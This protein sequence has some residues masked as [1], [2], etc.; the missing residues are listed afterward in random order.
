MRWKLFL[1][2]AIALSGVIGVSAQDE[3]ARAEIVNDE[4]GPVAV[5]GTLTY[6]DVLFT[7]GV[8]EPLIVLEDQGGFVERNEGFILP[9]Q[10]QVLGQFTSDF[11][12][13][14]VN[15]TLALPEVPQGTMHD[16]DNDSETDDGVQIFAI[17]YWTNTFGDSYLEERDLFG[18][19]WSNAYASTRA[20]SD[21]DQSREIVGGKYLV[22]AQDD[23]Q[24]FPNEFGEDGLLFTGDETTVLLPAGYT[25]VDMDTTPFTFDR[26]RNPVIDLI[27]PESVALDD[28]SN[29]SY[30]E[31]FDAM[32]EK[33]RTEYAFT[34][35]KNIDWDAMSAEFRP[36]FE[37]AEA[38][39]DVDAYLLAMRDFTW[40][41]PDVHVSTY[42]GGDVVNQDFLV[43]SAGGLGMAIQDLTDDGTVVYFLTA[44]G[45]A[46]Q[47]GIEI[48]AEILEINGQPAN[49]VIDAV[50]PFSSPF[51]TDI[52]R[53]LQQL[54]Y[55]F[56]AQVGTD[57][58]ITYQNPGDSDPTTVT[59]TT[60]E[61]YNSFSVSSF[62]TGLTGFELP[63]DYRVLDSGLGYVKI[64]SF[65]DNSLLTIQLWERMIQSFNDAGV[66][67]LIIDMRQNG[68]GSGFLADQMAA[69]F[70][71]EPLV[72]G[73]GSVYDEKTGDWYTDPNTPSRFYLPPENLRYSGEVAVLV[74][75]SCVSACEF[76]SYAMTLEDRAAIVGQYPTAG[77]GGSIQDFAM[78]EGQYVRIPIGRNLDTEG[79][80][81]IEGTGVVPT[82]QVP[83]TLESLT[84]GADVVLQAAEAHLYDVLGVPTSPTG[85]VTIVDGG[86][87]TVDSSVSGE[88]NA[89]ERV[90]YTL[91]ADDDTTVN[92]TVGDADG[93]LDTYLRVYDADENLLA[94][95]DDIEL[96][97]QINSVI[98]GLQVAAGTPVIIEVGTYGD[99]SAGSFTLTVL[100]ASGLSADEGPVPTPVP[101]MTEAAEAGG[102]ATPEAEPTTVDAT[103]VPEITPE[104]TQES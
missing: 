37:Q 80:I 31:A 84:S 93:T 30:T 53:R 66:P 102:D 61:E 65:F 68:G 36:R 40:A 67:G 103:P 9:P 92:I 79:N 96:G 33:F 24:G 25:V 104:A 85:D 26:S 90:R 17:A 6:T 95:N 18:G 13:S 70:F 46:E 45:P 20:S 82:V 62:N 97:V 51:S 39:N 87:I 81:I 32:V 72:I 100:D 55:V 8:A 77:G 74:G 64:Y 60:V 48:G 54:R 27:E 42:P 56:R 71:D 23:Q 59:L 35:L 1:V 58:E 29:L 101:E 41:I 11:Y 44:G 19:G 28:F 5:T 83:V 69:Y 38:D 63:L 12:E 73:N 21:V 34:E 52:N 75:P 76:F 49:D 43:N 86:E 7:A 47:A 94:E 57:F 3:P 14:P 15:Y 16:V 2:L 89:G 22:Y 91:I 4:G 99:G 50:V 98:E 10:S 88:V 78:P